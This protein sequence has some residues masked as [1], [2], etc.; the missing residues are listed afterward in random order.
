MAEREN[1]LFWIPLLNGLIALASVL[2]GLLLRISL[3]SFTVTVLK[4][5]HTTIQ[6][7]RK[8]RKNVTC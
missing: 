2:R 4:S 5:F 3:R 1:S 7:M 8:S 6:L